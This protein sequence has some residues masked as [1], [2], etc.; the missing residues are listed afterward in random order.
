[1]GTIMAD[2]TDAPV[3]GDDASA[4]KAKKKAKRYATWSRWAGIMVAVAAL[5][6]VAALFL[7]AGLANCDDSAVQASLKTAIE[8]ASQLKVTGVTNITTISHSDK[9][10]MCSMHVTASAGPP[11]DMT[12][13]LDLQKDGTH[14][15]IVTAN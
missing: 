13:R 1:M 8:T 14:F 3:A 5:I 4:E 10:A 12:Y 6:R 11:S 15:Q 9:T 7:P 2:I